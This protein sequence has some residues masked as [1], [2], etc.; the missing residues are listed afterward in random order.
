MAEADLTNPEIYLW[1]AVIERAAWDATTTSTDKEVA[2]DREEARRWLLGNGKYFREVCS[3]AL[4][5][6]DAVRESAERM[7]DRGWSDVTEAAT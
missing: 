3:L 2:Q 1:R 4:F 7:R 6:A 5:D